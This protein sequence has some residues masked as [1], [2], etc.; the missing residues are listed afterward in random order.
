MELKPIKTVQE[1]DILLAWVDD[2]FDKKTPLDS[3]N[4]QTMKTTLLFIK[5]YE[6]EHYPIKN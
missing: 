2:R 6:D 1:Y 4:A 3:P 5:A